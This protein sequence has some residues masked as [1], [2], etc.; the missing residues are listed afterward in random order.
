MPFNL[1]NLLAIS[2]WLSKTF[3]TTGAVASR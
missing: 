1:L 3:S 2:S